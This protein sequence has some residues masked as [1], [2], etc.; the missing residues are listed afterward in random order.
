MKS[1]IETRESIA[2]GRFKVVPRRREVLAEGRP[3]ELR[4]RAFDVLMALIDARGNIL[5][6]DELMKRAWPGRIVEEN[7]LHAQISSLRKALAP[8]TDLI[9]TV[10][11][12]GYLFAGELR[13]LP[14]SPAMLAPAPATNVPESASSLIGRDANV[15]AVLDLVAVQR[16][17][18]LTGA[19]GIGK[20]RL[21]LEVARRML[22]HFAG[23]VWL[24][25]L[26]P[27][28][29]PEHLPRAVATALGI[30]GRVRDF[31]PD[32]IA[33]AMGPDKLL[34]VLDNCEHLIDAAAGMTEV[35]LRSCPQV[36]VVATSQEPLRVEGEHLY[37]VPPLD[38]P[39]ENA[40]DAEELLKHGAAR[41]FVARAQA[42]S[43]GFRPD[44]GSAVLVGLIARRLD[45][46]PLAIELAAARVP[47]MGLAEI[48]TRLKDRFRLLT[49][50]HRT[51]LPRHQTLR[52]T[53]DW[54]YELLPESERVVFRRLGIFADG[55][56]LKAAL[57][58]I[59]DAD[60]DECDIVDNLARLVEK[61]LVVAELE[62]ESARYRLLETTRAY[63]LEKLAELGEHAA[64]AR[65]HAEY[66]ADFFVRAE[67]EL[68]LIQA[69]TWTSTYRHYIED[70]RA[71][72]DWAF[73]GGG[74][75]RV[76]VRLLYA[77]HAL[78]FELA[79]IEES[80]RWAARGSAALD[81]VAGDVRAERLQLATV[82]AMAV[83]FSRGL[84]PETAV[85]W[86]SVVAATAGLDA[87]AYE[88]RAI[89]GIW[90][91]HLHCG[92]S[93]R[94]L[95]D[96]E[97]FLAV[98]ERGQ[99]QAEVL[100]GHRLMGVSLHF[101]G[102]QRRAREST[103]RVVAD[104]DH[105]L[106]RTA[107]IGYQVD[108]GLMARATLARVLWLQGLCDQ[109]ATVSKTVVEGLLT[110]DHVITR[111][112]ILLDSAIPLA[113]MSGALEEARRLLGLLRQE[114]ENNNV[115]V[116]Q[117][118]RCCL[119]AWLAAL[120]GKGGPRALRQAL[121]DLD[122]RGY[123]ARRMELVAALAGS[124][125]HVDDA[126]EGL[127]LLDEAIARA[128]REQEQWFLPEL[129]RLKGER[130]LAQGAADAAAFAE[131][132][133]MRS[134]EMAR[135]QGALSWEL[136]TVTSLARLHHRQG[137][138]ADARQL[139]AATCRR[140]TEGFGTPDQ[141]AARSLLASIIAVDQGQGDATGTD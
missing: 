76:G 110:C 103:E 96:A 80:L 67:Q 65:R 54:S 33:K 63:A 64:V 125:A 7:S 107:A 58:V 90:T 133:F 89:W 30:A 120:R 3:I 86:E 21:G 108:Q 14:A 72:L 119:D 18:T 16:L 55:V 123:V 82:T 69:A 25:E 97:R 105:A 26:G 59:A 101:L 116:W 137:Q 6:K 95:S 23:G 20:T 113:L 93:R 1:S 10:A 87:H 128:E 121:D 88:M 75:P 117:E 106:H 98:A 31:T 138:N 24:A 70:I 112:F 136:R 115:E 12:R 129:L 8:D 49:G 60:V 131:L 45:G 34:L 38:L 71:A 13:A 42:A 11:G 37:P 99:D 104:Y 84:A 36:S 28:S 73:R 22:P 118:W 66:H 124:Y 130:V 122:R 74:D 94:A 2:F 79:L 57:A 48:A 77:A 134:I 111:C 40:G 81:A 141:V 56:T 61:S 62:G 47:V 39:T 91:A 35:L 132:Q 44:P 109:A 17:V 50:G 92:H 32:G 126:T 29:A 135:A 15:I 5:S 9:R 127:D 83:M 100:M 19:G 140:F 46:I 41:L 43:P 4:A 139:L 27:L 85:A 102:D 51:A 114:M 78:M 53:L 52:A 68:R